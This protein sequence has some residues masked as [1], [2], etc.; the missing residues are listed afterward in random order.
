MSRMPFFRGKERGLVGKGQEFRP[1]DAERAI[2][3][4]LIDNRDIPFV[5]LSRTII[6]DERIDD[7]VK[8]KVIEWARQERGIRPRTP[9]GLKDMEPPRV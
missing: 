9:G 6:D 2:I 8:L 5:D 1:S 4:P 3:D 7:H